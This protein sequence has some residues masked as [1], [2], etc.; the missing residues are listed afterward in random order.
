MAYVTSGSLRGNSLEIGI[1]LVLQDR[2]SNQAKDA[3]AAIRR[4]HN[5]AKEAVTANLQTADSILGNVYNGF[6]NVATGITNTVL[7]GAEFIDTMTTVSAITGSTREQLQMLSETAQSLGL[8]TMFGSQNIASGMKYLAMAGNTFEQVNDMIKGAAYV[9]NATGMELG[10]KGGAADLITN[11]MKTFKIVGD[12]ASE[13]VGDQLTKATLSANISMTDLAESIKYS[14][15]D[16][17]MLKKELPEVA[18]MIGTLGNAGIQGSMAGTSLGNMA[19]Y[20]IKAFN[21]KTDAYSFLQRMGLSQQDFVDAQGDLIDFGDI[22]E[23][24]SK[25]VENLPSIDRGK[26]IGAIFG[27]RGQRAA[28]AIMNDLEGY[29]NLLD[30]IQNNSAG[31]AK[32]IVDKRMNTLAGSIDKVSSAWENLKVAFTEQIGP[33]LMPILNT[34]SQIIEAVR[35]F[36]TTPVGA[37]ASQ[38]FVLSTFIGLVGTKVLQLITKWRLLRSDT[39]I[40]FTNMFRLIRGGWQGATLD[41]QNYMRLQGLLNAQTTYGLPYYASMAKHLGTP[42]GGVVYD[43]RTK[44]W[45]SHDQSVTGLGKGT[46]MKEK[47][48]IRYTETHGT[49]KQVVAGFFGNNPNTKS[50]WWTKI[51]GNGPKYNN[52]DVSDTGLGKGTFMKE[53]DAIRYTETHGTGKQVVAGFFGNNPNTKS[54]WWTK[55]LGIGSKLFSGLSLVSLGLTLIMPLIKMAANALDKNTKQIEKNT[56]S[57]N[58]LAGKFLTEEERKKAGKNLDLPQEVKA[59]NTTLG[60]LQNYLK[61]NNAVPVINITVDQSG[62]I[63]KKEITKS[64]QLD[65]QTL[66]AKN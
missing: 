57:V 14:A 48:A 8:E 63:L 3:S 22:M 38:V 23:K 31:F 37:F 9:A 20:L 24:I 46:F 1:A 10:G 11:V 16:M 32:S 27:V 18:A 13:L 45:R 19:R 65:I 50:T 58:T 25:G 66:G 42:V 49:G 64:N 47:D 34:I 6:L 62:N 60:A 59:L 2:F 40:G 35:E 54:T 12:G 36:V 39:Q 30:Q 43:Q 26:A 51:L 53:K 33:A 55:I 56:F 21:P 52:P 7:Q 4:L 44:R 15:A 61:N 41:L 17:V 5:E 29:R 28:N